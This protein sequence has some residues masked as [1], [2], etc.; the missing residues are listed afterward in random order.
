MAIV[1]DCL[2]KH[3]LDAFGGP[4]AAHDSFTP[5]QKAISYSMTSFLTTGGIRGGNIDAE[6]FHPRSF[7]MGFSK[8]V[9]LKTGGFSGMRFGE[10]LDL[11]MRIKET[12]SKTGLIKPAFVYHKRRTDFRKFFKQ[13]HNSGI[14]RINLFK[15]HPGTL[16]AV[17]FLPAAFVCY[18]A[19]SILLLLF[20]RWEL[21]VV[22]I[23]Y[24]LAI[25]TDAS[26]QYKSLRVGWL[27]VIA[28]IVQHTAYGT[29]F[30]ISFW[31]RIILR[32]P[33]FDAY[34]V[35]FYK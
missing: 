13:V 3:W 15:R 18:S 7:N 19:L 30:L 12:G 25:F 26:N 27:S 11:S 20:G 1:N 28:T 10:D 16:K 8:N 35:N 5:V 21:S 4:D 6:K 31:K 33:E 32:Q 14:A 23:I 9:F 17:H 29:G 34:S 22:L 24:F 2:S